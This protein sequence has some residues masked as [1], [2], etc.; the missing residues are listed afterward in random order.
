MN[1]RGAVTASEA[2]VPHMKERRSGKIVNIASIAA[3]RG[4]K[5]MPQYYASKAAVLSW[6]QSLA[7]QL[8]PFNVN[9][10]AICPGLLWTPMWEAVAKARANAGYEGLSGRELFDKFV[11]SWVPLGRE[12]TPEDVGKLAAFL[13]SDDAV[14][15]TGQ[16]INL[17]GGRYMN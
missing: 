15:I 6:T 3:R 1:L 10:N 11:E 9:V 5:D 2:V 4:G 7:T 14:N 16:A 17:D 12:Q 8:A 13:A